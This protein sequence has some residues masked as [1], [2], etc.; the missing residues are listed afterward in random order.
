MHVTAS[1]TRLT[2]WAKRYNFQP[3]DSTNGTNSCCFKHVRKERMSKM[4]GSALQT[5]KGTCAAATDKQ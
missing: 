4:L 5:P 2:T 3:A 1:H